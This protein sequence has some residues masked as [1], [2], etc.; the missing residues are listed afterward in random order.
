[1]SASHPDTSELGAFIRAA[2]E[3]LTPESCGLPPGKRRRA[4]GLRREEAAALC[5]ISPTWFTWIEQGRT[6]AIS[7]ATLGAIARGLKLSRAERSYLFIL[8]G[9]GE[10][11]VAAGQ[12]SDPHQIAPL[13][14]AVTAPAYVLDRH[15]DAVA[16]NKGAQS[17]FTGWLGGAERNLLRYVFLDPEARSFIADW[18]TRAVRLV[19]EFR[20]DTADAPADPVR[21]ALVEELSHASADFK[22]AWASQAVLEREGG[23]RVFHTDQGEAR[24]RQFTLRPSGFADLRLI[25]L[26]AEVA[27]GG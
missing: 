4:S 25:V 8:A 5:H 24:H 15:W 10:P 3:R 12:M 23:L 13:V 6:T 27:A 17:L 9:R 26:L 14:E 22:A 1:M 19:A 7:T 2:R 16:W 20:A 21:R 18:E 11:V